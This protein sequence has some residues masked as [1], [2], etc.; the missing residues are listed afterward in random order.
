MYKLRGEIRLL[1]PW[2][3]RDDVGGGR[4]TLTHS[5]TPSGNRWSEQIEVLFGSEPDRIPKRINRWGYARETAEWIRETGSLALAAA[6]RIRW[7]AWSKWWSG[8]SL[9]QNKR[10]PI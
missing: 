8:E 9:F 6:A 5:G 3:G 4:I 1:L 10:L 7:Y 2:I